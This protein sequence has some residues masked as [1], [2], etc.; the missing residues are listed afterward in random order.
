MVGDGVTP[1]PELTAFLASLV[2]KPFD[3]SSRGC[4]TVCADWV[5]LKTGRDPA[6]P[7]RALRKSPRA[8]RRAMRRA[9]GEIA[10]C[11]SAMA[12]IGIHPSPCPAG[13]GDVILTRAGSAWRNGRLLT[14]IVAA[15][16]VGG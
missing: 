15:I 11:T 10:F 16:A 9:G 5:G 13:A 12:A 14:R 2:E 7:W 3:W 4:M 6:A 8:W 1:P